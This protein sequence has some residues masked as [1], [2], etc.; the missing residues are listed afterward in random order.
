MVAGA[1]HFFTLTVS[2]VGSGE[3]QCIR[4]RAARCGLR[5]RIRVARLCRPYTARWSHTGTNAL[6][7][8]DVWNSG[9]LSAR[10]GSND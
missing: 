6:V 8:S 10:A 7:T 4:L 1:D 9:K 2:L 3:L 5:V